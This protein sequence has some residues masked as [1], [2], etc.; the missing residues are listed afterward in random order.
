M[1]LVA[2]Y[3]ILVALMDVSRTVVKESIGAWEDV[4]AHLPFW[5]EKGRNNVHML[6]N[7]T[8]HVP[9][10]SMDYYS[11]RNKDAKFNQHC[12]VLLM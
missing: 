5:K 3:Q 10:D 1:H 11:T 2:R 9:V 8:G 7:T 4:G 12:P 6:V